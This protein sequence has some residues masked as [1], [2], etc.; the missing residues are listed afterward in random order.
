MGDFLC[1][2]SITFRITRHTTR[3]NEAVRER[4]G[5]VFHCQRVGDRCGDTVGAVPDCPRGQR[6]SARPS[7]TETAEQHRADTCRCP[8][9]TTGPRIPHR[10]PVRGSGSR[11][12]LPDGA[13]AS[14]AA[15]ILGCRGETPAIKRGATGEQRR[16]RPGATCRVRKTGKTGETPDRSAEIRSGTPRSAPSM[17]G[18]AGGRTPPDT[19]TEPG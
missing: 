16:T 10:C 1:S 13:P 17:I 6:R 2:S 8:P 3:R 18:T 7:V 19:R 5:H 4:V 9:G 15:T 11:W 14:V 12:S